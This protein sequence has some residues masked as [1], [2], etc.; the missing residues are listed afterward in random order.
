MEQLVYFWIGEFRNIKKRGFNFGSEY[1]YSIRLIDDN[2]EL[3]RRFNEK[4]IKDFYHTEKSNNITNVS[5]VVGQN[6]TGKSNFLDALKCVLSEDGN[7]FPYIL[8]LKLDDEIKVLNKSNFHLKCNF[9]NALIE[10]ITDDYNGNVYTE[11]DQD[12]D[13]N[14]D[15]EDKIQ[16][17]FSKISY[18]QPKKES[19]VIYYNPA[20]DHKIYPILRDTSNWVDISTDWLLYKDSEDQSKT[21][22]GISQIELFYTEEIERQLKLSNDIV[23]TDF[24]AKKIR[25]PEEINIRSLA[26]DIPSKIDYSNLEFRN[27]SKHIMDSYNLLDEKSKVVTD[28]A[29]EE[30][31]IQKMSNVRY[32][33]NPALRKKCYATFLNHLLKNI[34]YH[35]NKDYNKIDYN[36]KE[37]NSQKLENLS[38]E[39]GVIYFIE[40]SKIF[41]NAKMVIEFINYTRKLIFNAKVNYDSFDEFQF[42]VHK[43]CIRDFLDHKDNYLKEL[44]SYTGYGFPK[45]FLNYSWK[46]LSTGEKAMF[47]LYS[48][49][50]RA[51]DI[52][53]NKRELD[54]YNH[55]KIPK[56]LYI[57]IDEGELGFH[58]Q[59]QKEYINS[60]IEYLP[61]L[62]VFKKDGKD[63][64]PDIQIIF[65]THSTLSLSDIPN[66]NITYIAK[67]EKNGY[68]SILNDETRPKKSF[69]ANV[70]SLMEDSFFLQEGLVG[71]FAIQKINKTIKIL[72]SE[73]QTESEIE[74]VQSIINIIDEPILKSKLKSM[75]IETLPNRNK[76][77][78]LEEMKKEIENKINNLKKNDKY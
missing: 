4:Y 31:E 50:Y 41:K 38:Y 22:P 33:E 28:Y 35:L 34:I 11:M 43:K 23:F 15:V 13:N 53:I 51:K 2:F 6:G 39:D 44:Q 24:L 55:I 56:N 45:S 63:Y 52:I 72:N 76:I 5:A 20:L 25:I 40:N 10:D 8:V 67:D 3:S 7:F 64:I 18:S 77:D 66:Y 57:L 1:E 14:D 16:D 60:L 29:Q 47:N 32:E 17:F 74:Y 42:T 49:F 75:L 54:L 59:W 71:D 48:R 70:H 65:T 21:K 68:A 69:G 37:L 62:F 78:K 58:L 36:Y 9:N 12:L 19:E 61:Q 26:S 30:S 27:I 73:N 46:S